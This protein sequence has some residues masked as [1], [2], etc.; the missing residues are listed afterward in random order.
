MSTLRDTPAPPLEQWPP[1]ACA[2]ADWQMFF[3]GGDDG[4]RRARA[5][6]QAKAYCRVC[7]ARRHCEAYA[8]PIVD[9]AG[10][11]GEM[12]QSERARARKKQKE[13]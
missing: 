1:Q 13:A 10:V 5:E 2:V 9:L 3:P 7:D 8:L 4:G 6:A 11:W 12:T